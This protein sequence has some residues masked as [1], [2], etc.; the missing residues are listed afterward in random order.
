MKK[1]H[2]TNRFCID[3]RRLNTITKF[4]TEAMGNTEDTMTTLRDDQNVTK[5][6]SAKGYWQIPVEEESNPMKTNGS[7]QFDMM[8]FGLV[9]S[10]AT[11]NK[12]MRKL[13]KGCDDV[14]NYV[15]DILGHTVSW[16]SHLHMLRNVFTRIRHAS[17]T[18]RPTKCCTG[19]K[20][21]DFTG[22]LVCEG[23]VRMEGQ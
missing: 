8:P 16:D 21:I 10:G 18:V 22:H 14:D 4:D 20:T 12:M 1:N 19:Y 23:E 9:N 5:I 13:I 2:G 15:D 7:Y 3:F 17:L 6:D 11:F